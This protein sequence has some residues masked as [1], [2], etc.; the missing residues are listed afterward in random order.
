MLRHI[1]FFWMSI[2][3]VVV[4]FQG[5]V[6]DVGFLHHDVEEILKHSLIS[7]LLVVAGCVFKIF[8][9]TRFIVYVINYIYIHTVVAFHGTGHNA[10]GSDGH[11]TEQL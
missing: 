4:E 3:L 2:G 11:L 8:V 6:L 5:V 10:F 7:K 1:I 9:G